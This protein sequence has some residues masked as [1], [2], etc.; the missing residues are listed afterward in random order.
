[1][2]IE[3]AITRGATE[4][5]V[6]VLQTRF[7]I[8]RFAIKNVFALIS[9]MYAYMADRIEKQTSALGKFVAT[10]NNA[11]LNFL[12]PQLYWPPPLVLIRRNGKLVERAGSIRKEKHRTERN[13]VIVQ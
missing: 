4:V 10:N 12:L 13:S 3:E 1:M 9:N 6:I 5:D 2:P 8:N 11:I 7:P